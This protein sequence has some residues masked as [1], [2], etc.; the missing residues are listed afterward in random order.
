MAILKD[1]SSKSKG[2]QD[3]MSSTSTLPGDFYRSA[4]GQPRPDLPPRDLPKGSLWPCSSLSLQEHHAWLKEDD[5][6]H[7]KIIDLRLNPNL[8]GKITFGQYATK[9]QT[10]T[11]D[12]SRHLS[13]LLQ[14]LK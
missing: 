11:Q 10:T 12:F 4:R 5:I 6:G 8:W 14:D 2:K 9:A 13:N 3:L 7:W 1:R